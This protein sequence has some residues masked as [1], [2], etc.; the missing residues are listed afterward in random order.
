[1]ARNYTLGERA[2]IYSAIAG[3]ATRE[4]INTFLMSEQKKYRLSLRTMPKSSYD[5]VKSK[6]LPKMSKTD[7]WKQIHSPKAIGQLNKE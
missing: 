7:L 4:E 6:Y 5:M 2:I 3:G 1:M